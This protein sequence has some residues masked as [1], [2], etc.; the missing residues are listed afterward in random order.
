MRFLL[1]AVACAAL[2]GASPANAAPAQSAGT[3]EVR[4]ATYNLSLNRPTQGLLREH[5]ANPDVDDV[6]RRQARNVAEVIQRAHPDVVLINEFDYDPEAARLFAENFLAVSQN[7]APAQRYPYRFVAPSNTGIASGFD[8][9][10]NGVVD[11]TPGDQAYGDDSFGFGLFPGQY[12]MVVYSKYPIDARAV[13]TFQLFKWKDM[14]GNT[15]PTDFYS[16]EEQA[17]LRLSSK[18]H[19]DVPIRVGRKSVHFLVSHPTP[20]TFDGPEDRNGRRNHDEIRF[21]ADYVK[22]GKASYVYDD[23]GKKGG[24]KPGQNFVIAGDQNADP[25]D[26]DSFQKAILQLTGHPLVNARTA[27]ASP[28]AA[29]ASTLQGGANA[30]HTGDPRYDTADFSDTAP[31]NLRADYVLP[32]VGNRIVRSG[33]FWPVRSDPLFRLTGVF[34]PAWSAVNGFPTSDHRL[35]WADLRLA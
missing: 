21:W 1:I 18:S 10:N 2:I 20:P 33:V 31:G 35:V 27:P 28:G 26:G 15:M 24:L 12:G 17:A 11:T 14:P 8:L 13:R 16:A 9:N 4:F 5:L 30:N 22:P 32:R 7:G 6:Y 25:N 19:W 23:K 3:N 29:E 34:D